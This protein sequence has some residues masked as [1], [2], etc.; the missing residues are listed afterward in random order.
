RRS[1]A[2]LR[3]GVYAGALLLMLI[4]P[5][6]TFPL[7][8]SPVHSSAP[9]MAGGPA[10]EVAIE[11]AVA[12]RDPAAM[13]TVPAAGG[14]EQIDAAPPGAGSAE[15]DVPAPSGAV[16]SPPPVMGK[17]T[18]WRACAPYLTAA[19]LVGVCLML[20][21]LLWRLRGGRRLRAASWPVDDAD[22]LAA[23]A[24]QARRIGLRVVPALAY[25]DRILTPLVVGV[26]RPVVLLPVSLATALPAGEIEAILTHELAHIRRYDHFVLLV[27]RLVEALLFFHPAVWFVSR[28]IRVE[29]EN[30]CD[31]AAL[32][33]GA[34]GHSY[35]ASLVTLAEISLASR[36]QR[37]PGVAAGV[38]VVGRASGLRSRVLRLIGAS[39][40]DH[41]R[42]S[43]TW[44]IAL[45]LLAA[46]LVAA[47]LFMNATA[48][49]ARPPEET[50]PPATQPAGSAQATAARI[51]EL[52]ALLA[53]DDYK[54]RQKAQ[55]ALAQLGIP[56]IPALRAAASDKDAER[57][58]R[59][60]RALKQMEDRAWSGPAD[61][62]QVR[63][64]P[65]WSVWQATQTPTFSLDLRN[66]GKAVVNHEVL[67]AM[68]A[69]D[70]E[71]D[72]RWYRWG[73][74]FG[75]SRTG[76]PWKLKPG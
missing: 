38:G 40:A 26:I 75:V 15:P 50:T 58:V 10:V 71:V 66:R 35:A 59:A 60:A 73:D 52:I 17:W 14:I 22:L 12:E 63:V 6:V 74:P 49:S 64:R 62:L 57:A 9:A 68:E 76:G 56:A 31:D 1:S 53:D 11:P 18:P 4:C 23:F 45:A 19:Y 20:L 48:E 30:C 7:V 55:Q 3:Y 42:L 28:R 21:R 33:A 2:K 44:P 16:N 24:G 29:R 32:A 51:A 8:D 5:L 67:T 36:R 41:A 46:A 47:S 27:Q 54:Q 61:G 65:L 43:R 70:V 39:P 25:C 72:G 34:E 13:P 69:C 37:R